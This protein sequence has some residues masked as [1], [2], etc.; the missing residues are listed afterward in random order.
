MHAN[1]TIMKTVPQYT[2]R[3]IPEPVDRHLRI[4][5]QQSGKSLNQVVIDKLSK[6]MGAAT[7]TIGE[8]LKWFIG[9]GID[10]ATLRALEEDDK[11]QKS[12]AARELKKIEDLDL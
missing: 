10:D 4:L 11:E 8:T 3:N 12:I 5:A 1:I 9:S 6:D 2:I 7:G